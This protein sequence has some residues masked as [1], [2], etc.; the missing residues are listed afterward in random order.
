MIYSFLL[1]G[2]SNAAGRGFLS[3]AE[4]LDVCGGKI[5]VLRNGCW[6]N[7]FRPINPDRSFSGTCL[8]ESFSKA[9]IDDNPSV[10]VGIIPC[11]DGGTNLEQWM[12]NNL[13]FDNAVNCAKLAMRTSKLIGVLWHQGEG[14]CSIERYPTYA[15]RFEFIMDA[16]RK[17]LNLHDLPIIVGGLGDFLSECTLSDN[18]KN[19]IFVN[20][21]LQK[22]AKEY[23]FCRFASAEGL[24]ANPDNLHFNAAALKEFGI[25]YYKEFKAI[26]NSNWE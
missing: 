6:Q 9:F 8:A 15:E 18:L 20:Q 11:A 1:I 14:D 4:P 3:E 10:E 23:P 7:M 25:R 19:Y 21:Q 5:K 24:G 12:P 16:L 22:I 17:E 26:D 13:L 2:Q